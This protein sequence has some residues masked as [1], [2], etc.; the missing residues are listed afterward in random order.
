MKSIAG[1]YS[2]RS[3]RSDMMKSSHSVFGRESRPAWDTRSPRCGGLRL[4]PCHAVR[5]MIGQIPS[6]TVPRAFHLT[7]LSTSPHFRP[8]TFSIFYIYL[9]RPSSHQLPTLPETR[10]SVASITSLTGASCPSSPLSRLRC[11]APDCPE[12][13]SSRGRQLLE[14]ISAPHGTAGRSPALRPGPGY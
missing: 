12:A 10:I 9:E 3:S 6:S 14:T 5:K 13:L 1:Q 2:S 11:P 8:G 7:R 4:T